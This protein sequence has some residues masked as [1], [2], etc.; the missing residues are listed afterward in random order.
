M[1]WCNIFVLNVS[2]FKMFGHTMYSFLLIRVDTT[3]VNYTIPL[4]ESFAVPQ[5]F[6]QI[7]L[8]CTFLRSSKWQVSKLH[9]IWKKLILTEIFKSG[10]RKNVCMCKIHSVIIFSISLSTFSSYFLLSLIFFNSLQVVKLAT[11]MLLTL[12]FLLSWQFGPFVLLCQL[13]CMV[14]LCRLHLLPQE[15]V[16]YCSS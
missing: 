15:Q 11:I 5:L 9:L 14:A 12:S 2:I 4:R 3:R 8:I 6:L 1:P 16:G 7:L 13:V 10:S